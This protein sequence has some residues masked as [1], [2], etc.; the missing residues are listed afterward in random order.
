MHN[1]VRNSLADIVAL[2]QSRGTP[3]AVIGG[4]AVAAHG[5]PRLTDDVDLVLA[6]DAEQALELIR[7][8]PGTA[9][10][11]LF[12]GV[13]EVVVRS[14]ILPLRHIPSGTTVD[15][16]LGLSGFERAAI[17]RARSIDMGPVSPPV[18]TPEDL[19][20]MKVLASRP[21][22][23]DD[24]EKIALRLGSAI[25]WT[26]VL[27]TARQLDSYLAEDLEDRL[28]LLQSRYGGS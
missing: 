14:S 15:L 22:D 16:A 10:E 5:E 23:L 20:I 27:K 1:Q 25:D 17:A 19:L 9:F 3:F 28:A 6:I 12:S 24:V 11:P 8:L 18:V 13:E 7:E 4:V 21:R 2:L 26:Y